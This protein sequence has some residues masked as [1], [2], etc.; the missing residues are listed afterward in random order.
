MTTLR[1]F[2]RIAVAAA[3]TAAGLGALASTAAAPADAA[4]VHPNGYTAVQS[5]TALTGSIHYTPGLTGT[6]KNVQAVFTGTLSGCSGINGAETGTGTVTAVLSG[7]SKATAVNQTGTVTVNWP[8][9]SGLNPSNG[10]LT[11]HETSKNGPIS[12]SG[13]VTSGAYTGAVLSAGLLPYAHQGAGTKA[14]PLKAQTV[15]NTAPFAAMVNLG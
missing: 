3:T 5:C 13:S 11:L 10:T 7:T 2:R 1:R 15:T 9:S 6:A 4:V 14:H 8:T 12:V